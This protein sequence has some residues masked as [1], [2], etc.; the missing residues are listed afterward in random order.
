MNNNQ[1]QF[2]RYSW[3]KDATF[4]VSGEEFN[5]LYN[6]VSGFL[7]GLMTPKAILRIADCFAILQGKLDEAIEAGVAKEMKEE[8]EQMPLKQETE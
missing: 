7:N 4:T 6:N 5:I 3:E 8:V 2:K 1:Q